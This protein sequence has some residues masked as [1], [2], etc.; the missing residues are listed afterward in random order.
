MAL[1]RD[2]KLMSHAGQSLHPEAECS[3]FAFNDAVGER[4]LQLETR[5]GPASANLGSV[6]QL[7][8]AAA[9]RLARLIGRVFPGAS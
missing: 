7:D 6:L 3:A 1:V 5:I 8:R 4:Y 2:I 9:M